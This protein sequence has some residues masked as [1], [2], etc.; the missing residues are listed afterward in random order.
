MV[1]ANHQ[2]AAAFRHRNT[3]ALQ[4]NLEPT[5]V[6]PYPKFITFYI[7]SKFVMYRSPLGNFKRIKTNY[8]SIIQNWK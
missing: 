3:S 6:V 1:V 5:E 8:I 2:L 7:W 4:G